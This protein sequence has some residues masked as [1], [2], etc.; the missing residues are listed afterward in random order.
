MGDGRESGPGPEG[1]AS[2][3]RGF[4]NKGPVRARYLHIIIWNGYKIAGKAP[5]PLGIPQRRMP[6][7]SGRGRAGTGAIM[8]GRGWRAVLCFSPQSCGVPPL[9]GGDRFSVPHGDASTA[10]VWD[11]GT[12]GARSGC[13]PPTGGEG[14][15]ISHNLFNYVNFIPRKEAANSFLPMPCIC[16]IRCNRVASARNQ[17]KFITH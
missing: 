2:G 16:A 3:C 17:K 11:T 8:R 14:N 12:G 10:S 1:N 15:I 7:R 5:S 9:F 13:A 6:G 4:R